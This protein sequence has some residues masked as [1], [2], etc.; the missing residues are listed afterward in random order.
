MA[1]QY[2]CQQPVSDCGLEP[3]YWSAEKSSGEVDFIVQ[4]DG[5][6]V[7]IEVKAEENLKAKSLAVFCKANKLSNAVRFSLSG[8]REESWMTNVPL[9]AAACLTALRSSKEGE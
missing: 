7:P 1:E 8:Y 2:V 6:P 5:A 9:Y 3:Y 4:I